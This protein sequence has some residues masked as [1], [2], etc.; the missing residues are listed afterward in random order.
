MN[1]FSLELGDA[2]N[3]RV[4][5]F[6]GG[7]ND[8]GAAFLGSRLDRAK[9]LKTV[10]PKKRLSQAIERTRSLLWQLYLHWPVGQKKSFAQTK[11][12]GVNSGCR[13]L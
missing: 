11:M 1:L 5:G 3:M 6:V 2:L 10:T 12:S 7:L 8:A 9:N 13:L 4:A